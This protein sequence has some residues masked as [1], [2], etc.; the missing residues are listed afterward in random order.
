[1]IEVLHNL[2]VGSLQDEATARASGWSTLHCAKDPCHRAAVGYSGRALPKDH[3][4]YL[5]ARRG[6]DLYLNM[7]DARDPAYISHELVQTGL[8]FLSDAVKR[9]PVLVHCNEGHSRAPGIALLWLLQNGH[10]NSEHQFQKLYPD[11]AP[12]EGVH[13]YVRDNWNS[14][15]AVT[16]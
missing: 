6:T 15:A 10:I 16:A 11:Y 5:Y 12:N 2:F 3:P 13:R 7:V 4:E 9:G 1:M 14:Y 8:D